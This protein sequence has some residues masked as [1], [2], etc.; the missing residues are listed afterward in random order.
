MLGQVHLEF[1]LTSFCPS[2]VDS[3][4][5]VLVYEYLDVVAQIR[6]VQGTQQSEMLHPYHNRVDGILPSYMALGR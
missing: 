1:C 2:I 4:G 5:S 3:T 6:T